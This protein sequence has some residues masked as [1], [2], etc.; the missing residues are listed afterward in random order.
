MHG[1]DLGPAAL[2]F[3]RGHI[4]N[5]Q[6]NGKFV[7]IQWLSGSAKAKACEFGGAEVSASF[8]S[9]MAACPSKVISRMKPSSA[10]AASKSLPTEVVVKVR[11]CLRITSWDCR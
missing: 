9:H 4:H 5:A 1:V 10:A 3:F 8:S 11:T 2:A 6:R 7:H